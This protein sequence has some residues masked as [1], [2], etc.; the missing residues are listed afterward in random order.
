MGDNGKAKRKKN[1]RP[2]ADK[3]ISKKLIKAEAIKADGSPS[4]MAEALGI[5]PQTADK[6]LEKKDIQKAVL[7]A[8]NRAIKK[9]GLTRIRAYRQLA[10]QLSAKKA[11]EIIVRKKSKLAM[12]P[13]YQAQDSA[14]K[15]YL[16]VIGDYQDDT[17]TDDEGKVIPFLVLLPM[18]LPEPKKAIGV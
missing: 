13:D 8:R 5:S 9:A 18:R 1:G 11:G 17:P 14:R 4:K 12:V 3:A 2:K 7:S 6:H 16:K 10:N 15:D